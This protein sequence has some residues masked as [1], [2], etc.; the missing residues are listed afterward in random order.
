MTLREFSAPE[1]YD[2]ISGTYVKGTT[3]RNKCITYCSLFAISKTIEIIQA[4]TGKENLSS[5]EI[6]DEYI[7]PEPLF[8][9]D[10]RGDPVFGVSVTLKF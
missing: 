5:G 2:E 3:N 9:L 6:I 1:H 10:Q 8:T 7:I 4:I